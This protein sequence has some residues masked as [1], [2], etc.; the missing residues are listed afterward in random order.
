[1]TSSPGLASTGRPL[2]STITVSGAWVSDTGGLARLR[3]VGL[4]VD[5]DRRLAGAP[6]VGHELV[7]EPHDGGRDRRHGRRAERAD[8]RLLRGPGDAGA[9]VVA[10]VEQQRDVVGAAVPV[11]DA[12][13]D[14]LQPAR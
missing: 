13:Q 8:R 6:A 4:A 12:A 10:D 11:E 9:D 7:L 2:I 3:D 5:G 14:L 1:M